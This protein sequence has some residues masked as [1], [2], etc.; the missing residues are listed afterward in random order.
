MTLLLGSAVCG[1]MTLGLDAPQTTQPRAG[2]A[3]GDAALR[4]AA[5][6]LEPELFERLPSA[7]SGAFLLDELP[8]TPCWHDDGGDGDGGGGG[9]VRARAEA[10]LV[11]V[12]RTS[13]QMTTVTV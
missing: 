5:E 6:A 1:G 8:R 3:G 12:A 9:S 2:T 10:E 13:K 7:G 4:R 11:G